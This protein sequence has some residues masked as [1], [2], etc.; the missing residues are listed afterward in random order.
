MLGFYDVVLGFYDVVL[1]FDDVVLGFYDVVLGFDD[2]VLCFDDVMRS[3]HDVMFRFADVVLCFD[4]VRPEMDVTQET[5][6]GIFRGASRCC[7]SFA[8]LSFLSC[9]NQPARTQSKRSDFKRRSSSSCVHL[10]F[11]WLLF[12]R[13]WCW[14]AQQSNFSRRFALHF[15]LPL[16][17]LRAARPSVP[18]YRGGFFKKSLLSGLAL[19]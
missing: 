14:Q 10:A 11:E 5:Q 4:V 19:V 16:A 12:T 6:R 3:R 9:K 8:S 15:P 18:L 13:N 17:A 2:V 1:G 7:C